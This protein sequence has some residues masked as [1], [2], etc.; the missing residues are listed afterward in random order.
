MEEFKQKI[1]A[2][3]N[4]LDQILLIKTISD[5]TKVPSGYL[6]IGLSLIFFLFVLLGFGANLIVNIVG[7][8]YPAY[9]SFK[10]IES[11]EEHIIDFFFKSRT[12]LVVK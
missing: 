3:S 2:L 6:A 12:S 1:E 9:M 8:L 4:E 10:A 11:K 5:K 7:I